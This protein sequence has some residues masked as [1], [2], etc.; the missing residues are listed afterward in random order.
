MITPDWV[1]MMARYN[2][3]QNLNL[4]GSAATLSDDIRKQES[5]S[6]FGSIHATFNH[7]IWADRY[8]MYRFTGSPKPQGGMAESRIV[9]DEWDQLLAARLV[10]DQ[11]ITDWAQTL[12]PA[13]LETEISWFSGAKQVVVTQPVTQAVTHFFNHQTHHRGQIHALLTRFGATPHDTDLVFME[14]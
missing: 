10:L 5:G 6:F 13:W 7:L 11:T 14:G 1:R 2:H 4:T 9:Y 12:D 8:W 3:W